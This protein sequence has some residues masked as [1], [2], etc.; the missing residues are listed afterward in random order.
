MNKRLMCKNKS[1]ILL[2]LF[3]S[4]Q[5]VMTVSRFPPKTGF[6]LLITV[7]TFFLFFSH[8]SDNDMARL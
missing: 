1:V 8:L 4:L 6:A 3:S 5:H 2:K 7:N